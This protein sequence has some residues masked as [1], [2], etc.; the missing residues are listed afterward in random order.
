MQKAVLRHKHL[1]TGLEVDL[2]PEETYAKEQ[3]SSGRVASLLGFR[4]YVSRPHTVYFPPIY[5]N[6]LRFL[7][8]EMD[9]RRTFDISRAQPPAAV[10][11]Q[12]LAEVFEFAG[13]ARINVSAIGEDF[14]SCLNT[15]ENETIPAGIKVI[16]V[17]LNL[18]CPWVAHAVEVLRSRGYF[19][20]G[21]LPRWF[22][23]D[24][25]LMQKIAGRPH[26]EGIRLFSD[27]A[28]EILR[29]LRHDWEEV[30]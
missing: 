12:A 30:C 16:Q 3:I 24:G 21:I 9:D 20:G 27:R 10:P 7:Y 14:A 5:E 18:A 15:L 28:A 6:V 13:V 29:I 17:Y 23:D 19:L 2:M 8:S 4:T 25:M 1:E 26:W 22:D 11:S